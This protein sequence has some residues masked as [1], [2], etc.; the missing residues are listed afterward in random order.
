MKLLRFVS[1]PD[2]EGEHSWVGLAEVEL[3][4]WLKKRWR[5]DAG[6]PERLEQCRVVLEERRKT[7]ERTGSPKH[8]RR[9]RGD[10]VRH[11]V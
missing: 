3:S 8:G 5:I 7:R 4:V 6:L 2:G 9:G 10:M 1:S 11:L